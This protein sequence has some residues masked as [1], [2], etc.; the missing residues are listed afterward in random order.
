MTMTPEQFHARIW[1][2]L[3]PVDSAA[4]EVV[5]APAPDASAVAA[6]E[7]ATGFPVPEVFAA[8]AQRTNG[9]CIMAREAAWPQAKLYDV[10]PA[11]T[12]WRGL[13]MLG[14]AV[15]DLPEWAGI[16]AVQRE[17]ATVEVRGVLPLLKV[18]G[19]GGGSG[20]SIRTEPLSWCPMA[21][22]PAWRAISRKSSLNR[23]RRWRNASRTWP[24]ESRRGSAE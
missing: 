24:G 18:V 10:G 2:I 3:E 12:F 22:R 17:L 23:S 11:W 19:D 4:F 6:V 8:F 15:E 14:F 20:A 13:V 9:L 7:A 21:R 16:A 5:A 1:E